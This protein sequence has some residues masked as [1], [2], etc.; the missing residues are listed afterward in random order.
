[1]P[2]EWEKS[3]HDALQEKDEKKAEACE[4]AR[5]AIND[6]LTELARQKSAADKSAMEKERDRLFDAMR[7]LLLHEYNLGSPN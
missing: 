7:K 3:Y 2:C 1:M 4:R 5:R 6:R